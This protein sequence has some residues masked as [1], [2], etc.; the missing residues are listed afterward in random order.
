MSVVCRGVH[1]R[2]HITSTII[3]QNG[4]SWI[5]EGVV[6]LGIQSLPS[7]LALCMIAMSSYSGGQDSE[8]EGNADCS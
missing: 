2:R 6:R 3:V 7:S 4:S 5:G 8:G 1:A